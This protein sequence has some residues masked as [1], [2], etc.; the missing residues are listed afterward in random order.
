MLFLATQI[1]DKLNPSNVSI[2]QK[3][4]FFCYDLLTLSRRRYCLALFLKTFCFS[5]CYWIKIKLFVCFY[6]HLY[7]QLSSRILKWSKQSNEH[8]P[9]N[10]CCSKTKLFAKVLSKTRT[11]LMKKFVSIKNTTSTRKAIEKFANNNQR[12]CSI[13][14]N[15]FC[16]V[17]QNGNLSSS[18]E[19]N[20]LL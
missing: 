18:I 4:V 20:H 10:F 19:V 7:D 14:D 16:T 17:C 13:I 6:P 8:L 15:S 3:E 2:I 12:S 5:K 9:W 1:Y 11:E